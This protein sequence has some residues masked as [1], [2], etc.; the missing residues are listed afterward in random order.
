[1]VN[2]RGFRQLIDAVGGVTLNVRTPIPIGIGSDVTYVQPGLRK[3]TGFETQWYARARQG[4][5]DYSRMARQKCVMSAMLSQIS[6]TTMLTNFSSIAQA[7]SD[8][9]ATSVPAGEVGNLVDLAIKAKGQPIATL[10]LVPPLV[11]TYRPDI[12]AIHKKVA[13]TIARAEGR[14]D[15]ATQTEKPKRKKRRPAPTSVTG[16]SLGSLGEGYVANQTEDLDA[17]C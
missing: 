14:V 9:V 11:D 10:S 13:D 17:A 15:T 1:M 7:S 4:S 12:R 3:L 5:D 2:L 6:P 16:G 8:M